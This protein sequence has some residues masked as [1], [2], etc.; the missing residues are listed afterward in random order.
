MKDVLIGSVPSTT[1][2]SGPGLGLYM[3]L[4]VANWPRSIRA[5]MMVSSRRI[6]VLRM[7]SR[8]RDSLYSKEDGVLMMQEV[9]VT[10]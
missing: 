6:R 7:F 8:E 2:N 1:A 5:K 9:N 10:V 3:M 4:L